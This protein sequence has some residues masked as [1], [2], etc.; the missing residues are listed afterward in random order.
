[1][2]TGVTSRQVK[3]LQT[4]S[5]SEFANVLLALASVV[6]LG[7]GVATGFFARFAVTQYAK[8]ITSGA[9]TRFLVTMIRQLFAAAVTGAIGAGLSSDV[10]KEAILV[11]IFNATGLE[12]DDLSVES[13]KKA[14]GKLLAEKINERYGTT[15]TTFHPLDNAVEQIKT[16]LI[17]ELINGVAAS[18]PPLGSFK[19]LSNVAATDIANQIINRYRLI[20]GL[21]TVAS[22]VVLPSSPE[23]VRNKVRQS[24]YRAVNTR[25]TEWRNV[26]NATILNHYQSRLQALRVAKKAYNTAA[27]AYARALS[28]FN[29][30]YGTAL[31]VANKLTIKNTMLQIF[32]AAQSLNYT[33]DGT[34]L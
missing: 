6:T 23:R 30:G 27:S 12:I 16:Q 21:E 34:T 22:G 9:A 2:S 25:F 11:E 29:N 28:S 15:F 4:M 1:M 18:A 10:I 31:N 17:S 33:G 5:D 20:H 19:F 24:K 3:A 14:V 26:D 13:G 8:Y 7:Q 32:T